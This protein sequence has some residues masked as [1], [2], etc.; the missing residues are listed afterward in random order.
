MTDSTPSSNPSVAGP[1]PAPAALPVASGIRLRGWHVGVLATILLAL[2]LAALNFGVRLNEVQTSSARAAAEL[3]EAL[4]AAQKEVADARRK[5]ESLDEELDRLKDQR[6]DMEQLVLE[7]NRGRDEA[8]LIEVERLVNAAAGELQL[9]GNV[10]AG[11]VAL[12][13]ADSRLARADRAQWLALRRSIA[14]DLERLRALPAIDVTGIALRL[15]EIAVGI[16]GWPMLSD[17]AARLSGSSAARND[18]PARVPP[19]TAV[20]P[21][22]AANQA[23]AADAGFWDRTRAWLDNEFGDLVRIREV[24]TP[25]SVLLSTTQQQ[26]VR[27]QMRLRLFDARQ[28]LIARNDKIYRSDLHEAR[29]LLLRYFDLKQ[30]APASALAQ[31]DKLAGVAL[32]VEI[33]NA[34]LADTFGAMTAA[35]VS[36]GARGQ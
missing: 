32:S 11:I 23:P 36:R 21:S 5:V 18:S 29:V 31:I 10:A 17:P 1:A 22:K 7:I 8:L 34:A 27:H 33:P 12:Q 24:Q 28:A 25:E 26:L 16:D 4:A 6:A 15:D 19:A 30:A 13:A 3:Q 9:S 35:R 20:L 2:L 14:R